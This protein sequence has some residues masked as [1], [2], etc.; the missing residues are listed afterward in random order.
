MLSDHLLQV[1]VK[2]KLCPNLIKHHVMKAYVKMEIQLHTLL[3]L[4]QI[5]D[6]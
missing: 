6:E 1:T 5:G 3:T 2:V 4:A